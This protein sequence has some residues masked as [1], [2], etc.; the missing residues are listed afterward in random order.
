MHASGRQTSMFLRF[1]DSDSS[2]A[3][4]SLGG[5]DRRFGGRRQQ[6]S[7]WTRRAPSDEGMPPG[8]GERKGDR[9]GCPPARRP[10]AGNRRKSQ[11]WG[12][13]AS[14]G[15]RGLGRASSSSRRS[16]R[17]WARILRRAGSARGGGGACGPGGG[18]GGGGVG[19][20]RGGGGGG[21]GGVG[22]G[23]GAGSGGPPPPAP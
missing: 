7:P 14:Y 6:L 17:A 16:R 12:G 1:C 8:R 4:C 21:G 15:G 19:G 5:M 10:V 23:P 11:P 13:P 20:R 22:G 3:K 2:A 18:G 9:L